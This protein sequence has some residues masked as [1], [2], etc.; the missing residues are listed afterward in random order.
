MQIERDGFGLEWVV[1]DLSVDQQE[2]MV[3]DLE[4]LQAATSPTGNEYYEEIVRE[5]VRRQLADGDEDPL[6]RAWTKM[7]LDLEDR[8]FLATEIEGWLKSQPSP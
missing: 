4:A 5:A 1:A 3:T 2:Q 8:A 7:Y 6:A